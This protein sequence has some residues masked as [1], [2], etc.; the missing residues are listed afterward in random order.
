MGLSGLIAES[1]QPGAT[2][3][4][5]AAFLGA[6]ASRWI[7]RLDAI[8]IDTLMD[9]SWMIKTLPSKYSGRMRETSR[10]AG[11]SKA[12]MK[13]RYAIC[14]VLRYL[15]LVM[16]LVLQCAHAASPIQA[17]TVFE[18][19]ISPHAINARGPGFEAVIYS[20]GAT[21]SPS[22]G[23]GEYTMRF[24]G[25]N[26]RATI[27]AED[28]RPG[29]SS[30]FKGPAARWRVGVPQYSR[31]TA[32]D[33]Y[34]GIDV[35]WH[36]DGGKLEYDFIVQPGGDATG[37][38]LAFGAASVLSLQSNGSLLISGKSGRF[39]QRRPTLYQLQGG[40]RVL[41]D[42]RFRLI[43]PRRVG[44]EIGSYNRSGPLIIDPSLDFAT[45][46]GGSGFDGSVAVAL[47]SAK[48]IYVTG[49][50]GSADFPG[51]GLARSTPSSQ[52]PDV[53]VT[54]LDPQARTVLYS[55]FIGGN[56]S[57][58]PAGIAVDSAGNAYVAGT[59]KSTDFP[60]SSCIGGTQKTAAGAFA[61][62][63]NAAGNG[64]MW[65]TCLASNTSTVANGIALGPSG[66]LFVVGSV[67]GSFPVSTGAAQTG[68]PAGN[69]TAGFAAELGATGSAFAYAT[70]LTGSHCTT[71]ADAAAVDAVGNLFV[72]GSTNC[73][74]FPVTAGAYQSTNNTYEGIAANAFV[75]KINP[76]GSAFVYSTYLGGQGYDTGRAIA[77]DASGNAYITG[78]ANVGAGPGPSNPFPTTPGVIYP[79][80]GLFS[81]F[82]TK[83]DPSG[84]A[85]VYSTY[86]QQSSGQYAAYGNAI[87]LN[88]DGSLFLAQDAVQ[89]PGFSS[90]NLPTVLA[91]GT[92]ILWIN[93]G[94]T[95]ILDSQFIADV[96]AS[97]MWLDGTSVFLAG[98]TSPG[99]AVATPGAIQENLK[100]SVAG[101]V[102]KIE[103]ARNDLPTLNIDAQSLI[104]NQIGLVPA[105]PI[106]LSFTSS[107]APISFHLANSATNTGPSGLE[108]SMSFS[109]TDGVTPAQVVV[110]PNFQLGLQNP[111][112]FSI[113]APGA[114]N[115][116]QVI[117]VLLNAQEP[118][119]VLG[120]SN[121]SNAGLSFNFPGSDAGPQ[122]ET[123]SVNAVVPSSFRYGAGTNVAANFR[124]TSTSSW[125]TVQP[126]SGITPAN[127]TFTANPAG[128]PS[129]TYTS[130][131]MITGASL[132]PPQ[133]MV[134]I[135]SIGPGLLI[136]G[137]QP[138]QAIANGSA[139]SQTLAI[140]SNGPT[141][142]FSVGAAAASWLSATASSATTPSSLILTAD[143]TGLAA[144]SY[145][146]KLTLSAEGRQYTLL[147]ILT[148]LASGAPLLPSGGVASSAAVPGGAAGIAPGSLA[149][150][151]GQNF[152]TSTTQASTLPLPSQLGGVTVTIGNYA[153]PLLY[154]SPSQINLQVPSK[155]AVGNTNVQVTGPSGTATSNVAIV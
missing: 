4:I 60:T 71:A 99:A 62:K 57:D 37:I 130:F 43:S 53:F 128:L 58:T 153:A 70:Y 66:N 86:L 135:M 69:A 50:T 110:T 42:G 87:S 46:L 96:S 12:P 121:P 21:Y 137:L 41:V 109:V 100:G 127:L 112:Y 78:S 104:F 142:S 38:R 74:D 90:T 97:G 8:I 85:L 35:L 28:R 25:A 39:Q 14:V 23:H 27:V 148:V 82:L 146:T 77:V 147:V 94:A 131:V 114:N 151:Y 111:S 140:G 67:Q 145:S 117:A 20:Y 40:R 26:R 133:P 34:P 123:A 13:G 83:M 7:S 56:N 84:T 93:D 106:T 132:T 91:H 55:V 116:D 88:P 101:C 136:S 16:L 152:T 19:S 76:A 118:A 2:I 139:V 30:Y 61:F 73:S 120:F 32:K 5:Q 36:E 6:N 81:G 24:E 102:S 72:T 108:P 119:L 49:F 10:R 155:V 149:S 129:G 65:S 79:T 17:P 98:Q 103:F 22:A 59:T 52:Q 134:A 47:D 154:V 150:I 115:G 124:V 125:L 51:T 31:A 33:V 138:F 54:K 64:L 107:G 95:R 44:F 75:T 63:L 3:R 48:N 29:I 141:I 105:T 126:S 9:N 18:P 144:G 89:N 45:L 143:P 80:S 68:F 113:L 15:P 11:T 1:P 122:Q 92:A